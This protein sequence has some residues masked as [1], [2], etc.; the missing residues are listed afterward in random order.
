MSNIAELELQKSMQKMLE[1]YEGRHVLM[2]FIS[3]GHVFDTSLPFRDNRD[4]WDG[5]RS[6]GLS[7]YDHVLT[8]GAET[9]TMCIKENQERTTRYDDRDRNSD[10]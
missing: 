2:H 4:F 8:A 9:H 1:T 3:E 10:D 5:R 6:L 7:I